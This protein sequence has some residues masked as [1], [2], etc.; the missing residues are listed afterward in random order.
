MS[1][2][3]SLQFPEAGFRRLDAKASAVI[4]TL[5]YFSM[6]SH[7]LSEA[8][9]AKYMQF[10]HV[11]VVDLSETLSKLT[12]MRMIGHLNGFYFLAGQQQFVEFRIERNKRAELWKNKIDRAVRVMSSLP[13]VEALA[14]S[15]SLS[16]GT[17]DA[18]GDIDFL[19]LT[20]PGRAWT[21]HFFFLALLKFLPKSLKKHLCANLILSADKT[22]IRRRSLFSATEII[23]LRPQTNSALWKDF[24]NENSWATEFYPE[25]VP[26][27]HAEREA[28]VSRPA[29]AFVDRAMSG[30]FGDWCEEV[31]ER[32]MSKRIRQKENRKYKGDPLHRRW[33]N[34]DEIGHPPLRQQK[35]EESWEAALGSFER[36]HSVRLVRWQWELGNQEDKFGALSFGRGPSGSWFPQ[37]KSSETWRR[38]TQPSGD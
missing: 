24:F 34:S 13:F 5:A 2:G 17:Q 14:L 3:L 32:W 35:L 33:L 29:R 18:D 19:V 9:L 28:L 15:G 1:A 27:K 4:H 10:S 22:S 37:A 38:G 12:A 23:T 26:T 8:E 16:K 36:R 30:G 6:F 7:P 20:R 25:W 31:L 11:P 21:F